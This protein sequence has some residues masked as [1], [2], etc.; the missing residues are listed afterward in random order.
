MSFK[1]GDKV[2]QVM[3]SMFDTHDFEGIQEI[4]D[5][6]SGGSIRFK[7]SALYNCAERF[8]KVDSGEFYV[9]VAETAHAGYEMF[10]RS[11]G[12]Y[13]SFSTQEEA[14]QAAKKKFDEVGNTSL[15]LVIFEIKAR[16]VKEPQPYVIKR[17]K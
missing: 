10:K 3:R 15:S 16:Y 12:L 7:G 13:Q 17:I 4:A 8:K 1:V 11:N 2:V 6:N 9:A 14:E 5:I